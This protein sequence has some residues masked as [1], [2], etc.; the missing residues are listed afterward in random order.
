VYGWWAYMV[1]NPEIEQYGDTR[2]AAVLSL[3]FAEGLLY[4]EA[5]L[6]DKT[7]KDKK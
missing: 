5:N 1:P 2:G 4:T 7:E 3:L 6:V